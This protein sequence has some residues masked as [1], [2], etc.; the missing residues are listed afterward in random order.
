MLLSL[1]VGA[2]ILY[3]SFTSFQ[4]V[5]ALDFLREWAVLG[6]RFAT[7]RIVTT[8]DAE[9][10]KLLMGSVLTNFGEASFEPESLDAWERPLRAWVHT[11]TGYDFAAPR[12]FFEA[13]VAG[14]R[15]S[16]R[17]SLDVVRL[18]RGSSDPS[19]DGAE[20]EEQSMGAGEI[21]RPEPSTGLPSAGAGTN[22]GKEPHGEPSVS[23]DSSGGPVEG[24]SDVAASPSSGEASAV[25]VAERLAALASKDW[26]DGP[27]VLI[28]HSHTSESYRSVPPDPRAD[29]RHHVYNESNTGITRVGR[30][31]AE[32]LQD[33]YGIGTIHSTRIHNWPNHW[34]AYVNARVTVEEILAAYPSIDIVLD[35]HRQGIENAVWAT[36]V[37][38]VDAVSIEVIYTTSQQFH[39]AT[40]PNWKRNEA[41]ATLLARAMDDVH[42][43]LKNRVT[44]VHDR[45]YNQDLHPHMLLLEVGNYLDLEEH[46]VAAARLLADAVAVAL[47]DILEGRVEAMIRPRAVAPP[48]PPRPSPSS[49]RP[50]A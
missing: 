28:L 37:G 50:P 38:G 47:G 46:A 18:P 21:S 2:A 29:A 36:S 17:R 40:H 43:G 12:S 13:E 30:A 14:F 8:V 20:N 16:V 22:E 7:G 49:P 1:G 33:A 15:R 26:G 27:R 39:Y 23:S 25:T 48:Q 11:V 3:A 32:R 9:S 5:S 34:E 6:W 19:R 31:L 24:R 42:P 45:R 35:V 44:V 4:S 41:F 10:G